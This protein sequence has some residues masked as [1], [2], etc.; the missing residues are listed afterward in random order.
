MSDAPLIAIPQGYP[1]TCSKDE[2]ERVYLVVGWTSTGIPVGVPWSAAAA[3]SSVALNAQEIS[4]H[5]VYA[6]P[7]TKVTI[8]DNVTV[9][10]T[11]GEGVIP[12]RNFDG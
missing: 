11:G 12:V 3:A 10:G 9:E 6:I 8:D 7:T 1:L 2:G 4:G 5:L